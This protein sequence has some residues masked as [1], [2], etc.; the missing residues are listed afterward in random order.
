MKKLKTFGTLAVMGA[1][2]GYLLEENGFGKIHE[3]F[4]HFFPGIMTLGVAALSKHAS[5]EIARQCPEVKDVRG[6]PADWKTFGP[7][8]IAALGS[9]IDLRGPTEVSEVTIRHAFDDM[10]ERVETLRRTRK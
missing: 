3:V 9:T 4:D 8:S 1:Y 7:A 5:A 2:T 6:D 10:G